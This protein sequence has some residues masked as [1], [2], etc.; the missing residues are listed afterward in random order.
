VTSEPVTTLVIDPK[1]KTPHAYLENG[2]P[3]QALSIMEADP[4]W[5]KKTDRNRQTPLHIAARYGHLDVIRWLLANGADVNARAYNNFTALH[6]A[7]EPEVV[8]ILLA[9]QSDVN[10][11]SVGRTRLQEAAEYYARCEEIPVSRA[12]L[13]KALAVTRLLID[14]GADYDIRSACLL[15]DIKRIRHLLEN[16]RLAR[17]KSKVPP[18]FMRVFGK[19]G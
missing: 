7:R 15:G 11:S 3:T 12:E 16:K 17:D 8:K 10:A 4:T 5:V 1:L 18:I 14:A 2:C 6:F 19:S 9:H 13:D